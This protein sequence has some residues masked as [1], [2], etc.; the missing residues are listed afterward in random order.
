MANLLPARGGLASRDAPQGPSKKQAEFY[1][2][3]IAGLRWPVTSLE[4]A[5]QTSAASGASA[6]TPF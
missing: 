2:E 6:A 1:R 3:G 5:H 4:C